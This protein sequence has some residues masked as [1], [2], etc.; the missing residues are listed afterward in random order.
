MTM[1]EWQKHSQ[2]HNEVPHYQ[3]LLDFIDLR[4]Q[5][6]ETS[7]ADQTRSSNRLS[8]IELYQEE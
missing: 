5:V 4:A 2:S 6:S 3:D 7:I 8:W 1:F